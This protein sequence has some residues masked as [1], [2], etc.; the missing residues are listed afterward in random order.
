MEIYDAREIEARTEEEPANLPNE[1][2]GRPYTYASEFD[3]ERQPELKDSDRLSRIRRTSVCIGI[4]EN[5]NKN[6]ETF[7]I[8]LIYARLYLSVMLP[9]TNVELLNNNSNSLTEIESYYEGKSYQMTS[10]FVENFET[11]KY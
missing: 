3:S 9:Q 11:K 6:L 7:F 8:Q 10:P 1:A 5:A 4:D 2:E